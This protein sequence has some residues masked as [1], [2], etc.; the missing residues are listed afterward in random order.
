MRNSPSG[1]AAIEQRDKEMRAQEQALAKREK[2]HGGGRGPVRAPRGRPAARAAAGGRADGR[3]GPRHRSQADGSRRPARR[4]EPG[5]APRHRGPGDRGRSGPGSSSRKPSSA[6]PPSTPSRRRCRWWTCR[7][8]TSRG[9]SSGARAGTS[10]RWRSPRASTSSSTTRPG[11]IILSGFDPYRREIAKQAIERLI[12]DGRI[13]PA[14]IEEV[15]EKVKAELDE[16]VRKR[17]RSGRLRAGPARPAPGSAQ[18][19]GPPA[20]TGPAT[21]RTC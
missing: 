1:W 18:A 9:A 12:A 4:G 14:R 6:A 5:E 16:E 20:A 21:A 17:G 10:A 13:H 11:A 3:R 19:D 2:S 15:V 7:A 8:T